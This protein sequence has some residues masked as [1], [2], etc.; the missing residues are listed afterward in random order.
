MA[1]RSSSDDNAKSTSGDGAPA[2]TLT[3]RLFGRYEPISVQTEGGVLPTPRSIQRLG[4]REKRL[5][6]I[7]AGLVVFLAAMQFV[8]DS[9]ISHYH[10][11]NGQLQPAT[12]LLVALV[13]AAL[14]IIAV[15]VNRR[16]LVAF[17]CLLAFPVFG[18]QLG[19]PFLFLGGWLM[20]RS[21]RT[22]KQ[23]NAL[24]QEARANNKGSAP[25]PRTR[26]AAA[27]KGSGKETNKSAITSTANKRYTP[28]VPSRPT[29]PPP[30]P[31]W[32]ERRAAREQAAQSGAKKPPAD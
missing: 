7:G 26:G 28:K 12:T 4:E 9:S 23:F 31:S 5:S 27:A 16:A 2:K 8:I 29:P 21:L 32:I 24:R 30:K 18:Y 20:W 14:I 3:E 10:V 6:L 19:F 15:F 13:I 22:Q 25:A 17:A 1:Q 11:P